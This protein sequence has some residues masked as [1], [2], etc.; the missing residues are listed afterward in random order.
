M[1]CFFV[2][3]HFLLCSFV[4]ICGN[5]PLKQ[6]NYYGRTFCLNFKTFLWRRIY[7][8]LNLPADF[9]IYTV[10]FKNS[11]NRRSGNFFIIQYCESIRFKNTKE[12]SFTRGWF[13]CKGGDAIEAQHLLCIIQFAGALRRYRKQNDDVCSP[14]SCV[15]NSSQYI[16]YYGSFI[17]LL[18]TFSF[19]HLR[20]FLDE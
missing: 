19:F 4:K 13:A 14:T 6:N 3:T 20:N 17:C 8:L 5:K 1:L 18:V 16:I 2:R 12:V 11:S 7:V 9:F 10:L 15:N